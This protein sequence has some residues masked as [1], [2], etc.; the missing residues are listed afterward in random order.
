MQVSFLFSKLLHHSP[1]YVYIF[2]RWSFWHKTKP[3]FWYI[4]FILI[5]V[6]FSFPQL[7]CDSSTS[8]TIIVQFRI[9]PLFSYIFLYRPKVLFLNSSGILLGFRIFMNNLVN[10]TIRLSPTHF[11]TSFSYIVMSSD[12]LIFIFLMPRPTDFVILEKYKISPGKKCIISPM[13]L[14]GLLYSLWKHFLH[15]VLISLSLRR[16]L[17]SSLLTHVRLPKYLLIFLLPELVYKSLPS[18][19]VSDFWNKLSYSSVFFASYFSFNLSFFF[20]VLSFCEILK[21]IGFS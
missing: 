7:M 9:S 10:H 4:C 5:F 6:Q 2:H 14:F 15:V 18:S 16:A 19:F 11:K 3:I 21:C 8:C 17:L 20:S 1:K 12:F 13:P